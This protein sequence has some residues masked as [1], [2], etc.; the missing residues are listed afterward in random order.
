MSDSRS[1]CVF[2]IAEDRCSHPTA[3]G[4]TDDARCASCAKYHGRS[5]GLGDVVHA[6]AKA[7]GVAAVVE[8]VAGK[9]C[10]CGKRRA[11][12]NAAVPFTDKE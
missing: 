7:T 8:K 9:D 4:A 6:V 12:L 5:R 10:G 11:A 2:R 1:A 3:R